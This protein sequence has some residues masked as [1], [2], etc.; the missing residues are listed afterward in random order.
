MASEAPAL[1][2]AAVDRFRSTVGGTVLDQSHDD[3][4]AARRVWNGMI[5]RRPALIARCAS[6]AD[7]QAALAFARAE[8]L[9]VAVRGGGHSAAGLATCDGGVVIDL[10]PMNA[11]E[12]GSL[13]CHEGL[14]GDA[15]SNGATDVV[16]RSRQTPNR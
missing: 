10:T 16:V 7:V 13:A 12:G 4:D 8:S 5:D 15:R 11:V 9:T 14:L 6:T 3:Y 2:R 1:D